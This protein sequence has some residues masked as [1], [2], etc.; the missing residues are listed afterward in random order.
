ME[1]EC[2][3]EQ[4]VLH[5]SEINKHGNGR[6]KN[7]TCGRFKYKHSYIANAQINIKPNQVCYLNIV[8]FRPTFA[9]VF[10]V[11]IPHVIKTI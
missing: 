3:T 8:S 11:G 1:E 5:V 7:L 4:P 2:E 6:H 10:Q 9:F